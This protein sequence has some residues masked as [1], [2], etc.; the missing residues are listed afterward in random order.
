MTIDEKCES[1]NDFL[2]SDRR[3]NTALGQQPTNLVFGTL[4][5]YSE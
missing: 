5:R 2:G 3:A 1:V 4:F